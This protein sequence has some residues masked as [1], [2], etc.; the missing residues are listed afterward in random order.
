MIVT[1]AWGAYKIYGKEKDLEHYRIKSDDG[2]HII[3][4]LYH[5]QNF[6]GLQSLLKRWIDRFK[7]LTA[8]YLDNL[9][10]FVLICR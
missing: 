2:K 9:Y 4:G 6:N 10:C 1:N 8:K 3:K 7:G 5:I